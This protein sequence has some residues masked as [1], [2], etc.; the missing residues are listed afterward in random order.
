MTQITLT[1]FIEPDPK[2]A[3][4]PERYLAGF[5]DLSGKTWGVTV[6]LRCRG[7]APRGCERGANMDGRDV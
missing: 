4:V 6:P 5:R 3:A 7:G 1:T 2:D